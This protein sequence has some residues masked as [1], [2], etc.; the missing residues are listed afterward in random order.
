[1]LIATKN[2]FLFLIRGN[3]YGTWVAPRDQQNDQG[4]EAN[5]P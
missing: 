5:E 2:N 1:M 4:L 3:V